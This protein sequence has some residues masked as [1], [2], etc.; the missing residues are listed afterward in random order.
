MRDYRSKKESSGQ[1]TYSVTFFTVED[2]EIIEQS[3]NGIKY[4]SDT[5]SKA[6]NLSEIEKIFPGMNTG[7]FVKFLLK[8]D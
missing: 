6:L 1:F 7:E 4:Q 5:L 2:P 3:L 8:E